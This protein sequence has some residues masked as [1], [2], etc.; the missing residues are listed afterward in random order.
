MKNSQIA[1][2]CEVFFQ[3]LMSKC[4]YK[5]F[6]LIHLLFFC[7]QYFFYVYVNVS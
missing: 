7:L 1:T 6:D 3:G 5:Y 2:K 4:N